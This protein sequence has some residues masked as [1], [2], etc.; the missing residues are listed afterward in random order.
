MKHEFMAHGISSHKQ[1]IVILF[2]STVEPACEPDP[3]RLFIV[4]DDQHSTLPDKL[5]IESKYWLTWS[6]ITPQ[7]LDDTQPDLLLVWSPKTS[8]L[9]FVDTISEEYNL[10]YLQDDHK[11]KCLQ[12]YQRLAQ[13]CLEP[14]NHFDVADVRN[15]IGYSSRFYVTDDLKQV[16]QSK[17]VDNLIAILFGRLQVDDIRSTSDSIRPLLKETALF[18]MVWQSEDCELGCYYLLGL[19]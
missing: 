15:F 17:P 6:D 19:R 14:H 16:E 2:E 1:G 8:Q 11:D 18:P 13:A 12:F 4:L 3:V 5:T 9:P 7:W 10:L